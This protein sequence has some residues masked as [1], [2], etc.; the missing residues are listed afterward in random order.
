M[1]PKGTQQFIGARMLNA[2]KK[3][4]GEGP[5]VD[6][7]QGAIDKWEQVV[8]PCRGRFTEEPAKAFK[9]IEKQQICRQD[10][11]TNDSKFS[12]ATPG[13]RLGELLAPAWPLLG[14]PGRSWELGSPQGGAQ[15]EPRA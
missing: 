10:S 14:F 5:E 11:A 13:A 2:L 4:C 12:L 15:G 6:E 1:P 9:T 7:M 3:N 8:R